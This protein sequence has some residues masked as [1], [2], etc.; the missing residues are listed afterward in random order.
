VLMSV[1]TYA[2][3]AR[4]HNDLR[5]ADGSYL[6]DVDSCSV[7][8][9]S[10]VFHRDGITIRHIRFEGAPPFEDSS[11]VFLR[12]NIRNDSADDVN[13]IIISVSLFSSADLALERSPLLLRPVRVRVNEPL[14]AGYSLDYGIR[15]KNL[16]LTSACRSEVVIVGDTTRGG[17]NGG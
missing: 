10:P 4:D 13:G 16:S 17:N 1:S 14:P 3:W 9:A 5:A 11:S 15:L 7:T 6:S 2:I 12:F 8:S